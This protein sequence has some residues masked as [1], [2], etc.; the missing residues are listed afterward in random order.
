MN[1]PRSVPHGARDHPHPGGLRFT[2]GRLVFR[3]EPLLQPTERG[4][5]E[6]GQCRG[7]RGQEKR[8]QRDADLY[9]ILGQNQKAPDP[10]YFAT[11]YSSAG[12]VPSIA[13]PRPIGIRKTLES[14][15]S[16]LTPAFTRL[17]ARVRV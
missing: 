7:S 9:R 1:S 17:C 3:G 6:K 8:A 16:A 4:E 10:P 5:H 2:R 14:A 11:A 13:R 12:A 15:V